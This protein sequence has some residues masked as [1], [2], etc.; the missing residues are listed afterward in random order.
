MQLFTLVKLNTFCVLFVLVFSHGL[1]S[2]VRDRR[3]NENDP[4]C[5]LREDIGVLDCGAPPIRHSIPKNIPRT[6][7]IANLNLDGMILEAD[8]NLDEDYLSALFPFLR[9]VSFYR[10][11]LTPLQCYTVSQWTVLTVN[12]LSCKVP[13]KQERG[14]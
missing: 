14:K 11:L 13:S 1:C 9:R 5:D 8:E 10:T 4:D 2:S 3:D 7:H 6:T 12:F